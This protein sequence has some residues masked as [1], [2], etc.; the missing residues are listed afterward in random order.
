MAIQLCSYNPYTDTSYHASV[1]I[2]IQ[3]QLVERICTRTSSSKISYAQPTHYRLLP[4]LMYL[5]NVKLLGM[6]CFIGSWWRWKLLTM[7]LR[8]VL[9]ISASL[10][11]DRRFGWFL[12]VVDSVSSRESTCNIAA[13]I[14]T[15]SPSS[16]AYYAPPLS[17]PLIPR[18]RHERSTAPPLP[19]SSMPSVFLDI[20][21]GMPTVSQSL[22]TTIKSIR[23]RYSR[24]AGL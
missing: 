9:T 20:N 12:V 6:H 21:D 16:P 1:H 13:C 10:V 15:S 24:R 5:E 14:A 18:R 17:T 19:S 8:N 2:L 4:W 22:A 7:C 3:S 11:W 23:N